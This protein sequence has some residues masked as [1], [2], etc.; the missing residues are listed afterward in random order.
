MNGPPC[1][2]EG[3]SFFIIEKKDIGTRGRSGLRR[4]LIQGRRI[5]RKVRLIWFAAT[6]T[7][8]A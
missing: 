1:S 3:H 8:T 6:S 5:G 4:T 7:V 2:I